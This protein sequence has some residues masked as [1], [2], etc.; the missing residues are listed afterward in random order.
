MT[1]E[2]PITDANRRFNENLVPVD[3]VFQQPGGKSV[4]VTVHSMG[5]LHTA[6]FEN[7]MSDVAAVDAVAGAIADA[8]DAQD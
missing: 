1:V 7:G 6:Q 4:T 5:E 8:V 3:V 2:D